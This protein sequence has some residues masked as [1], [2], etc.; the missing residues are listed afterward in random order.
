[1]PVTQPFQPVQRVSELFKD[2]L[3]DGVWRLIV[4]DKRL[5]NGTFENGKLRESHGVGKLSEWVL[6]I[7]DQAN[8]MHAYYMDL[9]ATIVSMPKYGEL[10]KETPSPS[11]RWAQFYGSIGQ[12]LQQPLTGRSTYEGGALVYDDIEM[13]RTYSQR[14]RIAPCYGVDVTGKCCSPNA[15]LPLK[16]FLLFAGRAQRCRRNRGL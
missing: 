5:Y 2:V 8:F 9:T 12:A 10:Y 7:T 4:R 15:A 6:L 1:M 13:K 16:L 3:V 14:R 11:S